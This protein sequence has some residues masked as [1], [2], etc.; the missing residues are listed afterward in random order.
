MPKDLKALTAQLANFGKAASAASVTDPSDKGVFTTDY[1][2]DRTIA[3]LA[4][5][6]TDVLDLPAVTPTEAAGEA[7][8][9]MGPGG[10]AKTPGKTEDF[11]EPLT[12]DGAKSAASMIAGAASLRDK[13][14]NFGK[15]VAS[16]KADADATK[17]KTDEAALE[18]AA[19]EASTAGKTASYVPGDYLMKVAFHLMQS[20]TGLAAVN[21]AMD[22]VLGQEAA[23]ALVKQA[24]DEQVTFLRDYTVSRLQQAEAEAQQIKQAAAD[25]QAAEY[26]AELTKG[27]SAEQLQ[28]IENSALLIKRA[29]EI[30]ADHPI[31]TLAAQA[32]F[33]AAQKAAAAMEQGMPPE[34]AAEMAA[35]EGSGAEPEGPPNPQ[36][37]EA[38]IAVLVEQGVIS[39]E[40]AQQL[41]AELAGGGAGGEGGPP[42]GAE[43]GM[44]PAEGEMP[45]EEAAKQAAA[46]EA[47]SKIASAI[48]G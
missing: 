12:V 19:L 17:K 33:E 27:A 8:V 36:E 44:P 31:A 46:D 10:S 22:E 7:K 34:A 15:T 41:M 38:A 48:F 18:D 16:E 3:P 25:Q 42:P 5:P 9:E 20:P 30:F 47:L 32:G 11:V 28:A 39:P 14:A 6:K 13:L 24:A 43:G 40:E 4:G 23:C 21:Q 29:S 37:L 26:Y 35:Q 2:A 45:P 1:P